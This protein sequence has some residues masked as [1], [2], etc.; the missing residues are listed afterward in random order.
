[1]VVS[2][3]EPITFGRGGSAE[4]LKCVGID[5][6]ERGRSWTIAPLAEMD[7]LLPFARQ[8]VLIRV[9]ASPFLEDGV[10]PVQN[11]FIFLSGVFVGFY[12]LRGHMAASFP[13]NRAAVSGRMARLSLVIPTATSP[14]SVWMG[15]DLRE[16]GIYLS[17][18]TFSTAH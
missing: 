16:L 3:N 8:D 5:F 9:D 1:M 4:S 10:I 11:V 14:K 18:I 17:S 6:S 2:Y 12:S 15:E 7:I 13:I